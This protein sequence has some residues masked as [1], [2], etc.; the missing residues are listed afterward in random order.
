M[1]Q[2]NS[3]NRGSSIKAAIS[4]QKRASVG[5]IEEII[6]QER[7]NSKVSLGLRQGSIENLQK[8]QS[9]RAK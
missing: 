5:Q 8:R 2:I 6:R 3:M 7:N 4:N 1:A 9:P